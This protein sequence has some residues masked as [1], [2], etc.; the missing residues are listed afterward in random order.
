MRRS[1]LI[2]LVA[3]AL[4]TVLTGVSSAA[5][6]TGTPGHDVLVGTTAND[7][8][9]GLAGDDHIS[10]LRGGDVIIGDHGNDT[11]VGDDGK[12][13]LYGRAGSDVLYL[14]EESTS[15]S[16]LGDVDHAFGGPNDDT[17][18][19]VDGVRDHIDCGTG[20]DT[21][22]VDVADLTGGCENEVVAT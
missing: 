21:A 15:P 9:N 6:I 5:N 4:V 17:I 20:F 10:G 11:L 14:N 18:Y 12:D 2:A 1:T 8:I 3:I 22:F 7:N 16:A 19:A 13:S